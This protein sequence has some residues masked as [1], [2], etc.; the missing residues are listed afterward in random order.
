MALIGKKVEM[1]RPGERYSWWARMAW[2]E[3]TSYERWMKHTVKMLDSIGSGVPADIQDRL[4]YYAIQKTP[5]R[6]RPPL[7]LGNL[8]WRLNEMYYLDLIRVAKGFGKHFRLTTE[9]LVVP[10]IPPVPTLLRSRPLAGN[11]ER[12]ILLPYNRFRHFYFPKD[13]YR[14]EDKRPGIGWRGR[15]NGQLPRI[16]LLE[17]YHDH[18]EHDVGHIRQKDPHPGYKGFL[19]VPDHLKYRYIPGFEGVN[20]A[21]NLKWIFNFNSVALCNDMRYEGWF[22]EGRL[23]PDVHFIH[24]R[25]DLA[26]LDE[27]IDWYNRH[28]EEAQAIVRNANAWAKEF[29]DEDREDLIATLVL[30][31]YAKLTDRNMPAHLKPYQ[32]LV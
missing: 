14:W 11:P 29:Q 13:P 32:D 27:K 6:Y 23:K 9:F 15:A 10:D 31:R 8:S 7:Q 1:T 30:L 17:K 3:F 16:K 12:S 22:M 4:D 26:D 21:T 24:V 5:Y 28:P 18:P 2:R 25:R 19:S 20:E